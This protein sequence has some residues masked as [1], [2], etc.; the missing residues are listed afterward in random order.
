VIDIGDVVNVKIDVSKTN[1]RKRIE[2][3]IPC[4][5]P[6]SY[7][8]INF[9]STR[10]APSFVKKICMSNVKI[11]KKRIG[12]NPLNRK[13]RRILELNITNN[14]NPNNTA[15]VTVL[16]AR[17]TPIM[18]RKTNDSFERGSSLWTNEFPGI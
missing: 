4:L 16:F 7:I 13:Y 11:I 9:Q 3:K 5:N 8:L 6:S 15:Y 17:K 10:S 2:M 14:V 18:K 1:T 12:F